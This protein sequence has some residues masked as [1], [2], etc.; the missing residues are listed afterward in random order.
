MPPSS[1]CRWGICPLAGVGSGLG[2][3]R[4]VGVGLVSGQGNGGGLMGVGG[5]H[6]AVGGG[7]MGV[8]G[9][10]PVLS[11]HTVP[12]TGFVTGT[13]GCAVGGLEFM[14]E[15]GGGDGDGDGDEEEEEKESSDHGGSHRRLE[16]IQR[17]EI[18]NG[19]L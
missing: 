17:N 2:R 19:G 11:A 6:V 13:L 4:A 16:G 5:G 3:E 7:L 12:S 1:I 14:G 18:R 9:G 15:G 8:A 10:H